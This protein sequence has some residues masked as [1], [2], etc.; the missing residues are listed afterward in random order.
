V[1]LLLVA[2][3]LVPLADVPPWLPV[4]AALGVPAAVALAADRVRALG[5]AL[6]GRYVVVRSGS[7]NRRRE[8][9]EADGVIGWNLR[10]T[11]FQRRA[12]LTTLTATT[13]GGRQAVTA[14]DVPEPVAVALAHAA[15]P[16]LLGQFLV[17]QP[18]RTS[19]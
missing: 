14:L 15:H 9:L 16:Q 17:A 2:V 6:V 4:V 11:W 3:A 13:A 1:L 12:G 8:A 5:H 7:L 19:R 18:V 10:A